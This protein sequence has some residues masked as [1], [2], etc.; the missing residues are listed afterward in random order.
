MVYPKKDIYVPA[1]NDNPKTDAILT[2]ENLSCRFEEKEVLNAISFSLNEGEILCLLG[3][4]GS[5]KTTLLRLLA[6]LE[7]DHSGTIS[8]SGGNIQNV[9]PHKRNFGMMFQEYAL[10]PHKSVWEN[11]AFGLEMQKCNPDEIRRKVEHILK[12]M[13]LSGFENRNIDELSGGERQ[14]VA[15]ARSLAPEPALLLL[16]EPLGSLDRSLRERLTDEIRTILKSLSVTAVFVTHDQTEAFGIADKVAILQDGRLQQFDSPEQL[17]RT[18]ANSMVA[19]FLGFTNVVEGYF[20]DDLK[21]HSPMVISGG[22][23]HTIVPGKKDLTPRNKGKR[24]LIFRPDGARIISADKTGK[25]T[26][27][28]V[29]SGT[30]TKR[31]F[32]GGSYKIT[33]V[34][35]IPFSFDIPLEPP[36]PAMN[37]Q[38]T[39]HLTPSSIICV[40][41]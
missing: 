10:F 24:I 21:F 14:R 18:P 7:K 6:G 33:V 2:V 22:N 11:I 12:T 23:L 39:L 9:P 28:I 20:D 27:G 31:Q 3:P 30:I 1:G 40:D 16:D 5:G 29:L 32:Q 25:M 17:Y 41:R 19:R 38:I 26:E 35:G 4:S 34:A 36:P 37:E 15:L 13:G 8:F